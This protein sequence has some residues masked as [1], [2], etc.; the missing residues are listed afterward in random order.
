[1]LDFGAIKFNW[2]LARVFPM[3]FRY[4]SDADKTESLSHNLKLVKKKFGRF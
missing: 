2:N 1:M 4:I 3:Q